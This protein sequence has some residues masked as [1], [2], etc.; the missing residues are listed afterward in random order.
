MGQPIQTPEQ[1]KRVEYRGTGFYVGLL[2][3]LFLALALLLLAVQNTQ[4]VTITFL[5]WNFTIPLFA[6]AVGAAL[7]AVILDE[8]IGLIWRRSRRARLEERAELRRL[9]TNEASYGKDE[10]SAPS[11]TE[12]GYEGDIET[13]DIESMVSDDTDD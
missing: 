9:R 4:Q 11:D 10:V 3:S 2:A 5:G 12:P 8:L 6:V 7:L 1:D 13:M